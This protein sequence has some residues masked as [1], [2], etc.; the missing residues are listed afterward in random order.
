M[1]H[2]ESNRGPAWCGKPNLQSSWE[3]AVRSQRF[4]RQRCNVPQHQCVSIEQ[5]GG[6]EPPCGESLL[7]SK[8]PCDSAADVA[9]W[10]PP[11]PSWLLFLWT[12]HSN[13]TRFELGALKMIFRFE[14]C[15]YTYLCLRTLGSLN[16]CQ[17]RSLSLVFLY[18]SVFFFNS[19][20]CSSTMGGCGL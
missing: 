1:I 2:H 18:A 3:L 6:R 13:S 8:P 14:T 9:A 15:A 7:F 11:S 10:W 4:Q 20:S 17:H 16:H 5:R 19:H 12:R